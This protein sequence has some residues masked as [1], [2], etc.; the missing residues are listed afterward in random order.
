ML[1]G[2]GREGKTASIPAAAAL[3][4]AALAPVEAGAT[5]GPAAAPWRGG[6]L[7]GAVE[8]LELLLL[9]LGGGCWCPC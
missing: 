3:R 2:A 7:L 4:D 5:I 6:R 9:L 1:P 8:L